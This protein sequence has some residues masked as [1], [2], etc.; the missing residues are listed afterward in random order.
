KAGRARL[1]LANLRGGSIFRHVVAE[2]DV[3][4]ASACSG[5]DGRVYVAWID[6]AHDRVAVAGTDTGG[7]PSRATEGSHDGEH[8]ALEAPRC[9]VGP[10]GEVAVLYGLA[11]EP[12][13]SAKSAAIATTIVVRGGTRTEIA[14]PAGARI[15]HPQMAWGA[16]GAPRVADLAVGADG[17]AQ[18]RVIKG[19]AA[20]RNLRGPIVFRA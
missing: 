20:P 4:L 13:D 5:P 15:Y 12:P 17:N 10:G 16:D 18:L 6:P 11:A 7:T 19:G 3:G 14:A 9:A 1:V 8:V 2:G